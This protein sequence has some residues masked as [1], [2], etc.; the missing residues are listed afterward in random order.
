MV[1]SL[2]LG[3]WPEIPR[4]VAPFQGDGTCRAWQTL[5]VC[6]NLVAGWPVRKCYSSCYS[7]IRVL[8]AFSCR[9]MSRSVASRIGADRGKYLKRMGKR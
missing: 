2:G 5:L 7:S 4:T 8:G 9:L 1:V 3:H 6:P